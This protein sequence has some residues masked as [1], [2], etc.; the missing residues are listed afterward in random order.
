MHCCL[1]LSL[2]GR[3]GYWVTLPKYSTISLTFGWEDCNGGD[4][5]MSHTLNSQR[6]AIIPALDKPEYYC[7]PWKILML[8]MIAMVKYYSLDFI[9]LSV[10]HDHLVW[11]KPSINFRIDLF[12]KSHRPRKEQTLICSICRFLSSRVVK[13]SKNY[14]RNALNRARNRC[15]HSAL[16]HEMRIYRQKRD[17]RRGELHVS[18]FTVSTSTKRSGDMMG[19]ATYHPR[20]G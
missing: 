10:I 8:H 6:I 2:Y 5:M 19:V 13:F 11:L 17:R 3:K 15:C 9:S 7:V 20:V 4:S 1:F 12:S 14:V 18:A 16:Q